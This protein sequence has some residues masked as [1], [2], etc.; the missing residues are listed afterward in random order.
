MNEMESKSVL[1]RSSCTEGNVIFLLV[2][3]GHL[4]ESHLEVALEEADLSL[5]KMG[6]LS[7]LVEEGEPLTLSDLA[8]RLTCVRS[9]ITQL[10][11]RLEADGLVKREEDPTD[12]RGVRAALTGLGQ[13]RQALGA[14]K[15]RD[16]QSRLTK[17]LSILDE[18]KLNNLLSNLR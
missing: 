17:S 3:I 14:Q 1:K 6:A 4:L 5:A 2:Q 11:D 7:K 16:V 10:V 9:N 13:E 18:R 8:A 15:I 12:R